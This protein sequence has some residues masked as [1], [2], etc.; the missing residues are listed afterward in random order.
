M[1]EKM[2]K[3]KKMLGGK[4]KLSDVE[5]EAKMN[6]VKALSDDMSSL[7]RDKL[8]GL[9]KVT[10]ASNSE[11]G[12]KEGLEKAE[13]LLEKK[14]CENCEGE[15]CEACESPEGMEESED[16]MMDLEEIDKKIQ[17]L[18]KMKEMKLKGMK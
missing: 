17:E 9:K 10:V 13:E 8:K 3:M 6:V 15:G 14:M 11:E 12:L 18:Q 16:S 7:L 2:M 1:E 5:K 4:G